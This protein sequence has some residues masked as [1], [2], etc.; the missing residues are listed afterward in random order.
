MGTDYNLKKIYEQMLQGKSEESST[1]KKP[2]TLNEAYKHILS[3]RT[4]YFTK[5]LSPSQDL[6]AYA[7]S[8]DPD[9]SPV[10]YVDSETETKT[11][12]NA[13][14][15]FSV[16][17]LTE[18][19]L[20]SAGWNS[21]N[22]ILNT[23]TLGQLLFD[24]NIPEKLISKIV[25]NKSDLNTIKPTNL[26]KFPI[27]SDIVTGIKNIA[28]D[29]VTRE[30]ENNLNDLVSEIFEKRGEISGTNVGPG[31]IAL[32]LFTNAVKNTSDK[33]DLLFGENLIE[34]KGCKVSETTDK[35]G[36]I[37]KKVTAAA[38]GYAPYGKIALVNTIKQLVPKNSYKSL[39]TN[40]AQR[41]DSFYKFVE[42][43]K[44][45]SP[46]EPGKP[47][48]F[49]ER[50]FADLDK[51]ASYIEQEDSENFARNIKKNF[52]LDLKNNIKNQPPIN[53]LITFLK[54]KGY[55]NT[56]NITQFKYLEVLH[57]DIYG[58]KDETPKKIDETPKKIVKGLFQKLKGYY[59]PKREE[60]EN[61]EAVDAAEQA[62]A[63]IEKEKENSLT[64]GFQELLIRSNFIEESE[65][66]NPAS[67][68]VNPTIE[69]VTD[70]LYSLRPN[71]EP[72]TKNLREQ[73]K[74]A[75]ENGY[76][77]LLKRHSTEALRALVFGI[78]IS[79]YALKEGFAYLLVLNRTSKQGLFIPAG[80]Q[81]PIQ[82]MDFYQ[83][84]KEY[85]EFIVNF[86]ERQ[87]WHKIS[88]A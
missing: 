20:T 10:G 55:V 52:N 50:F 84:H 79:E 4:A 5:N 48:P 62:I 25:E 76:L 85:L 7:K 27:N 26:K 44:K 9:L 83:S 63:T 34:I 41:V 88:I 71:E 57:R 24:Y 18:K 29:L 1:S 38:L 61:N 14:K 49:T 86:D 70:I 19:L 21:N 46:L 69:I 2:R 65:K 23:R 73:I 35:K 51:L 54:N 13:I 32:S 28:G 72:K 30:I 11:I 59:K 3:E 40:I 33:G 8:V 58:H 81:T 16:S 37:H 6:A 53:D 67:N 64:V 77:N 66:A 68:G 17:N 60:F 39:K 75:L 78:H 43:F 31:E 36:K 56:D 15:S 80:L 42:D 87:G 12:N 47:S 22:P 74:H 82:L 45:K